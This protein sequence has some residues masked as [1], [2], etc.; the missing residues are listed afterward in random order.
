MVRVGGPERVASALLECCLDVRVRGCEE[1]KL[2]N[3]YV[4]FFYFIYSSS[5]L[6]LYMNF[7]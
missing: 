6:E 1:G 7:V 2:V 5:S 4:F 3:E